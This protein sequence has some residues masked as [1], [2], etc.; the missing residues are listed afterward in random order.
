MDKFEEYLVGRIEFVK[1]MLNI[2]SAD[3]SKY[4]TNAKFAEA[5]KIELDTL[6]VILHHFNLFVKGQYADTS[7]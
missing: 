5:L 7:E 6:E 3:M 4:D 2:F 1:N